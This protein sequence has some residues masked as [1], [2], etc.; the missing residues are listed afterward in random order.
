MS[1]MSFNII[2]DIAGNYRTLVALLAKMPKGVPISV[3]DMIDRGPRSKEVVEF[4]MKNGIAVMG[5]HEHLMIDSII[6]GNTFYGR[7]I[8]EYNGGVETK[9]S[10][11]ED[12]V[13][14]VPEEHKKYLRDL[15]LSWAGPGFTVTHA[16]VYKDYTLQQ[17]CYIGRGF[18]SGFQ[19]ESQSLKSVLWNRGTPARKDELGLQIYG[20]N[21]DIEI[22]YHA[23]DKG[24]YAICLDTSQARILTG[25]HFPSMEIFEQEYIG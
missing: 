3:G 8:W 4:F 18:L 17:S 12:G 23:D 22:K 14:R 20:H 25:M 24:N 21:S 11:S 6:N 2:G 5:N 10:Y 1:E 9:I 15:P 7:G 13:M 19:F 16:P